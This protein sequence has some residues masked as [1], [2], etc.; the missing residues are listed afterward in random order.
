MGAELPRS[1]KNKG[2]YEGLTQLYEKPPYE[3]YRQC[4]VYIIRSESIYGLDYNA[5]KKHSTNNP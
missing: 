3:S 1:S 5:V 2:S 4:T